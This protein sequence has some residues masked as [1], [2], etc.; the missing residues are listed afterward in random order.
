MDGIEATGQIRALPDPRQSGIPIIAMT[1]NSMEGHEARCL[2]AGMDT[3]VSKPATF[4]E[5][6]QVL[7]RLF[8]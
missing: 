5:I 4:A 6:R 1:A 7:Y 3:F 8:S 2:E